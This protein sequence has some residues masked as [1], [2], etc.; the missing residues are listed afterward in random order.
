MFALIQPIVPVASE[1]FLDYYYGAVSLTRLEI[2]AL[3]T[4]QPLK[5]NNKREISEWEEKK[6]KLG[7][8][9]TDDVTAKTAAISLE[10]KPMANGN[11]VA[12]VNGN[13]VAH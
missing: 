12:S 11:G 13:G 1:A 7:L 3:R 4:N 10:E 8:V 6:K 9:A 5:S 2:E